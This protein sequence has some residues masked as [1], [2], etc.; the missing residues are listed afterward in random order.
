MKRAQPTSSE[1]MDVYK[2]WV[3]DGAQKKY[4]R[5]TLI[6]DPHPKKGLA[7]SNAPHY[8]LLE[9]VAEIVDLHK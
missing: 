7:L 3:D 4:E 9:E 2:L 6:R 8:G 1:E 5:E